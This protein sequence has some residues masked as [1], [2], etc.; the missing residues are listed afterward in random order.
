MRTGIIKPDI[1]AVRATKLLTLHHPERAAPKSDDLR[2]CEHALGEV[3]EAFS[4]GPRDN[5]PDWIYWLNQEEVNVMAGRCYTELRMPDRA[6]TLLTD[7]IGNYDQALIRE[8]ALYLSWLAEDF[9]QLNDLDQASDLGTRMA[10]LVSRT[11]SARA[12]DR[13]DH[14]AALLTPNQTSTPVKEFLD[15]YSSVVTDES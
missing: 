6:V 3:E 14:V 10:Q 7:A 4:S 8:N 5:D 11:N 2:S 15:V 12:R 13:L 1:P 9:I